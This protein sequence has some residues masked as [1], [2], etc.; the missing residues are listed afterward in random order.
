MLAEIAVRVSVDA[1]VQ[2][3]WDYATSWERQGEWIPATR[4]RVTDDRIVAR[5]GLGPIHVTDVMRIRAW[6]P[7]HRCEMVHTGQ[8]IHGTG[9]FECHDDGGATRFAWVE[10]FEVPG[11][12]VAPALW[13]LARW[14]L[15]R[16]LE[17]AVRNLRD[18]VERAGADAR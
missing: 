8:V 3:V 10:R 13:W 5:T 6:T 15:R 17:R 2:Q 9:I 18:R 7:P 12:P 14:P 11:G 4:V 16:G 1:P